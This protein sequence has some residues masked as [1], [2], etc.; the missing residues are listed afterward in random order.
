MN[1][2]TQNKYIQ[3]TYQWISVTLVLA[4]ILLAVV[5]VLVII[6]VAAMTVVVALAAATAAVVQEFNGHMSSVR[7]R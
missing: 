2:I 1:E 4:Q 6:A 7:K 5:N 3:R